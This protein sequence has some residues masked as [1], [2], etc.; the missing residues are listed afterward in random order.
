MARVSFKPYA[1]LSDREQ[2]DGDGAI[3]PN[4]SHLQTDPTVPAG[5]RGG[6]PRR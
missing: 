6:A 2:I 1:I 3:L 4:F 5:S